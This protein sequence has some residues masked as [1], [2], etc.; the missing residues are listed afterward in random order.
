V[1]KP[2][3]RR[4]NRYGKPRNDN[5]MVNVCDDVALFKHTQATSE[6]NKQNVLKKSGTNGMRKENLRTPITHPTRT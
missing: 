5:Y 6:E 1:C 2:R 3:R 4:R